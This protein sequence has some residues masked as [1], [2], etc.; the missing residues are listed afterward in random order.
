MRFVVVVMLVGICFSV[1][2]T[3]AQSPKADSLY[4]VLNNTSDDSS[5][6]ELLIALAKESKHL[7]FPYEMDTFTLAL[8]NVSER[9]ENNEGLYEAYNSLGTINFGREYDLQAGLECYQQSLIYAKLSSDSIVIAKAYANIGLVYKNMLDYEQAIHFYN[10]SL[11]MFNT[12]P[13]GTKIRLLKNMSRLY[14]AKS[15]KDKAILLVDKALSLALEDSN[16]EMVAGLYVDKARYIRD[17]DIERSIEFYKQAIDIYEEIFNGDHSITAEAYFNLGLAYFRVGNFE[18]ARQYIEKKLAFLEKYFPGGHVQYILCYAWLGELNAEEGRFAEA[19]EYLDKAIQISYSTPQPMTQWVQ[20]ALKFKGNAYF[21]QKEYSKAIAQYQKTIDLVDNAD[22]QASHYVRIGDAYAAAGNPYEALL[23]YQESI[24]INAWECD[25]DDIISV[26]ISKE[27]LDY[28]TLLLAVL[29]KAPLLSEANLKGITRQESFESI[30][31][32]YQLADTLAIQMSKMSLTQKGKVSL[33]ASLHEIYAGGLTTS[34]KLYELTNDNKYL[35]T[36]FYFSEKSRSMVLL[37]SLNES[38]A[39]QFGGVPDS[40]VAKERELKAGIN[41]YDTK[42]KKEAL[43]GREDQ[44][45]TRLFRRKLH[46]IRDRYERLTKR[47]EQDYPI[48]HN[49]KYNLEV[50][51]LN[52]LQKR[53]GENTT[54]LE[55]FVSDE[56]IYTFIVN[57]DKFALHKMP[58]PSSLWGD[59]KDFRKA[60]EQHNVKGFQQLSNRLY[61]VLIAPLKDEPISDNLIIIP[62]DQLWHVNFD[63]LT[64]RLSISSSFKDFDYLIKAY[65]ISYANSATLLLANEDSPF[66]KSAGECLAFSYAD[67][68]QVIDTGALDFA[69]LRD[70]GDDL[71]GTRKEVREISHIVPGEY[72]YGNSASEHNFKAK[73]GH[74]SVLHLALHGEIDNDQPNNSRLYFTNSQ[75]SLEDNFLYASEIYNMEMG[76]DLVV[77][78]ACNTGTGQLVGGEGIMSL[79]RAF[80]Y[81]GAQSLLISQWKV[82]DAAAPTLMKLFYQNLK[83]GMNKPEALRHAKLAYLENADVYHTSPFYWSSFI[84]IGDVSPVEFEQSGQNMYLIMILAIGIICLIYFSI[85]LIKIRA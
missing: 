78:S 38:R 40:L 43:K 36:A 24:M 15:N 57:K 23:S 71:P 34:V 49:L 12:A 18:L 52:E 64:T 33:K 14:N 62:D 50:I 73:A 83:D 25:R 29:G 42:L 1:S 79:G 45:K 77:L 41:F 20:Q 26:P 65:N 6:I 2:Q 56:I 19:H 61:Q 69:V 53:L 11:A 37:G 17:T 39:K 85:R 54:L 46:E 4:S 68:T 60:I 51:S 31:R 8:K 27:A 13:A 28:Q 66:G 5:R 48:Y 80:Q 59:V 70:L 58:V 7:G 47:I 30:L 9:L 76:T 32:H 22:D 63:L 81:A 44:D 10:K 3:Y 35:E 84:L 55:Y 74:Y 21:L 82:S 72:Y 67:S 16:L 75:D